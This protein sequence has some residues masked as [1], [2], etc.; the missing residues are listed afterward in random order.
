M[1]PLSSYFLN[2]FVNY[3]ELK[4]SKNCISI[5][6]YITEKNCILKLVISIVFTLHLVIEVELFKTFQSPN[7]WV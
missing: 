3:F 1:K 2:S 4:I 5:Y 7:H 6:I